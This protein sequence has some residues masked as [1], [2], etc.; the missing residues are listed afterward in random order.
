MKLISRSVSFLSIGTVSV[1]SILLILPSFAAVYAQDDSEYNQGIKYLIAH[2]MFQAPKNDSIM[3]SDLT[4]HG[5]NCA[6]RTLPIVD[7][8]NCN[9]SGANLNHSNLH[10]A[11]LSHINLDHANINKAYFYHANLS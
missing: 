10:G 5:K 8:S 1:F 11:N 7:W 9:F 3:K 6:Q 2:G 4:L